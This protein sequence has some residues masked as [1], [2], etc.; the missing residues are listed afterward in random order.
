MP[1]AQGRLPRI[2]LPGKMA[3]KDTNGQVTNNSVIYRGRPF[4]KEHA[5]DRG[6]QDAQKESVVQTWQRGQRVIALTLT[7]GRIQPTN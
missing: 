5:I 6:M 1:G 7:T 2:V 3:G 4:C